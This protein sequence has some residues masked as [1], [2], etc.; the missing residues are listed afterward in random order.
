MDLCAQQNNTQVDEVTVAHVKV[1][2]RK[3]R[4]GELSE[5]RKISGCRQ[6]V[7]TILSLFPPFKQSV[8]SNQSGNGLNKMD[9]RGRY[10]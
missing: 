2:L 9:A 3:V 10:T 5:N 8:P 6:G 1:G 7:S 4:A